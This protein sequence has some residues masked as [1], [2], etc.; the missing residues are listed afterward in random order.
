M[1]Q[2]NYVPKG[3]W[4]FDS[5]VTGVFDDMLSRSI[6]GYQRMRGLVADLVGHHLVDQDLVLDLGCS[7]GAAIASISERSPH[8]L[9]FMGLEISESMVAE[10]TRRFAGKDNV[11]IRR[12]DLRTGVPSLDC[13]AVLSVLT[14]QF[15][16]VEYRASIVKGVFNILKPG[17]VFVLVEKGLASSSDGQELFTRLYYNLKSDH[18]YS[19]EQIR[20]KKASLENVLVPLSDQANDT[21]LRSAGFS[22]V[23]MFWKDLVFSGWYAVKK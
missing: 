5:E 23:E 21:L 3:T 9:N 1:K 16:P 4:E 15:I 12:H 2:D 11:A 7:T 14:L 17:G 10:A 6:P 19:E 22:V 8:S 13:A 18:G 20:T